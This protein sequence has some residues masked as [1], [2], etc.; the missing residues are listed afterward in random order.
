M[1]WQDSSVMRGL[2]RT[3]RSRS[4]ARNQMLTRL[5][6]H[7]HNTVPNTEEYGTRHAG[8][9]KTSDGSNR[10]GHEHSTAGSDGFCNLDRPVALLIRT[11]AGGWAATPVAEAFSDTTPPTGSVDSTILP[12]S[13]R[14]RM[15]G[16]VRAVALIAQDNV[17]PIAQ[18]QMRLA[19]SAD[20]AGTTWQPFAAEVT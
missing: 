9:R 8:T 17:S 11:D 14:P 7:I 12:P 2:P 5:A 13:A 15:I 3:P 4:R 18:L 6:T 19:N 20:A 16:P 10:D 1:P